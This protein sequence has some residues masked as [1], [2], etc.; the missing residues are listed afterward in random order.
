MKREIKFRGRRIANQ[1]GENIKT[2]TH[3]TNAAS[4]LYEEL[5][6]VCEAYSLGNISHVRALVNYIK[7]YY[8]YGYDEREDGNEDKIPR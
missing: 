2:N 8:Y 5:N 3:L 6:K 7:E 1:T 4:D